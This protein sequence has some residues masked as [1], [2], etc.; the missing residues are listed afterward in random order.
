MFLYAAILISF[1][2]VPTDI[3]LLRI[4][5]LASEFKNM[6]VREEE[7]M[8]LVKLAERVPIPIKEAMDEPT[9]KV[10]V[11]LQ[12]FISQLKLDGFALMADMTYI[13][14]SAGR[15]MRALYEIVLR[16]GWASLTMRTL[17][18]CKMVDKRMWGSMIP[19]RQFT[20][21]PA[22]SVFECDV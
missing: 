12:S 15:L 8:E 16:R 3:E 17:T 19:L 2:L 13:T 11:L 1:A 21:I 9:A 7:K 4:F 5:S 10:N 14:Q 22:V 6:V 18:L 20:Q